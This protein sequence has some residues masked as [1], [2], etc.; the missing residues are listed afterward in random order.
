M[1]QPRLSALPLSRRGSSAGAVTLQN[2]RGNM[3]RM[4]ELSLEQVK[5]SAV[6]I[7]RRR[8]RGELLASVTG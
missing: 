2:E 3:S 1:P 7:A 6:S 4:S 8:L 5:K